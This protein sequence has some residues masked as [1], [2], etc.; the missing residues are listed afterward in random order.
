M[1][2]K[3]SFIDS[4]E[5]GF[6]VNTTVVLELT[7]VVS[8]CLQLLVPSDRLER[9]ITLQLDTQDV[10]TTGSWNNF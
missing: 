8:V 10:T 3:Y 9:N 5:V 1:C 7:G 2:A 6:T 4:A